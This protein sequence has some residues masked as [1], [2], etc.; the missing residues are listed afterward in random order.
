M[1]GRM[2]A[3]L[4]VVLV[5]QVT[6]ATEL[7]V[8]DSQFTIDGKPTFLLGCSYYA[9]LGASP[10]T[11]EKDLDGLR[12]LGFNWIR[13]WATWAGFDQ[14][15]SAVDALGQPR[16]EYVKRLEKLVAEC[17]QRGMI[18]NVT[19]SRGNGLN[20][21][22]SL[23]DYEAH[24]RAVETIVTT[25][26]PYRNWYIDLANERNIRDPRYASIED[27]AKLRTR[28]AKLD[29]TRLV[30]ASHTGEASKEE[31][32]K[33]LQQVKVDFFSLHRPREASSPK[34]TELRSR[35][36]LGWMKELGRVV[37]LHYDEPFRRGYSQ[38]QPSAEDFLIDLR[39]AQAGGAAG[40]C[41]HNGDQRGTRD[42]QPRRS[43]DL[44]EKTLFD[45]LDD[46]EQRFFEMLK[47]R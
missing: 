35:E 21:A 46:Q 30:T 29:P 43:F 8:R 24:Q 9:G 2:A 3:M 5:T 36:I 34:Q 47:Q 14:D 42:G 13:V 17:D 15:V 16:Q 39:G 33:Y 28:V 44:S 45:Q 25:L 31:L 10:Q 12:K 22:G 26:K 27:L 4:G 1:R 41:F 6:L 23:T 20:K 40:W 38:W 11:L 37:P 32:A 19:L 18:V 7:G